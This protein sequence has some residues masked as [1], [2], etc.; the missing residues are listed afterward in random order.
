MRMYDIIT[1]KKQGRALTD[2]EIRFAIDG[3]TNGHIPD[4]QMSALLM[5]I[6]LHGMDTKETAALTLAMAQSGDMVCLKDIG[7]VTVDKHST[8]GVGDK[9]TL[10]V[11][12]IA[13][14]CGAVVAKMSGRGLG[15]TGGTVDKLEAIPGMRLS[16]NEEEFFRIVRQTGICIVGQSGDLAPADKKIY[17]LRDATAT[18]DS[19]P[20][21]AA[22]IMSKKIAAGAAK[23]LLDVKTGSGAFMKTTEDAVNL[24]KI[25]VDL[26]EAA[27]RQT[28]ALVTNMDIPLGFA[29]GNAIEV[30]EAV[31][32]LRGA[33]PVDLTAV[34]IALA[35]EMLMLAGKGSFAEC[36]GLAREAIR[37]GRALAKLTDMVEA[38]GG[39]RRYIKNPG[40]FPKA[41]YAHTVYADKSGYITAMNAEACGVAAGMLGAGR[42][43]ITDTIDF[44]SGIILQA[45]PNDVIKANAP[46]GVLYTND[47]STLAEAAALFASAVTIG[48]IKPKS[49][50]LIAARITKE[51][52]A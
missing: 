50:P 33:G 45:K 32:V 44:A 43:T 5:A 30:A 21:I 47:K 42:Q 38:Q 12:P 40:L 37:S 13:A 36:E 19:I 23:I 26:G 28:S 39:D 14:A 6:C 49:K 31:S 10:V 25:M 51:S 2:E 16:L 46:L 52:L 3:F 34:C 27:G 8:G 24:A 1:H 41:A 15:H 29:I 20:L 35:A 18:V 17:A 11:S 7:G 22:S 9:T 4:Y 48:Q